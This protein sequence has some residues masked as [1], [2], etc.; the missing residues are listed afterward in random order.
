MHFLF[1]VITF[2]LFKYS[3]I[4]IFKLKQLFKTH[5]AFARASDENVEPMPRPDVGLSGQARRVGLLMNRPTENGP[6]AN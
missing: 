4:A 6:D 5:S 1:K 3:T 2:S